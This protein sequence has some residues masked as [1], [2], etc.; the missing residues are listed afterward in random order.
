MARAT[1]SGLH[2]VFM[3][4]L[5][6]QALFVHRVLARSAGVRGNHSND[7]ESSIWES[8]YLGVYPHNIYG[9]FRRGGVMTLMCYCD[10]D[11]VKSRCVPRFLPGCVCHVTRNGP[12]RSFHNYREALLNTLSQAFCFFL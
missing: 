4:W 12:N 3:F 1:Y 6:V 10:V 9:M 7:R 8:A 11:D 5:S 2:F